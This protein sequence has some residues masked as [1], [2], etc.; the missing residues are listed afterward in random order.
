MFG[1]Y[2]KAKYDYQPR[3]YTNK[4]PW[5]PSYEQQTP[6]QWQ[7]RQQT[8][9]KPEKPSFDREAYY[10]RKEEIETAILQT[11]A[12]ILKI[13]GKIDQ[14]MFLFSKEN[15]ESH[16]FLDDSKHPLNFKLDE[17]DI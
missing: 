1:N 3:E 10:K 15:N 11:N 6:R 13:N 14:L 9:E 7:P 8:I 16:N 17:N 4:R 12:N 2:N 5:A